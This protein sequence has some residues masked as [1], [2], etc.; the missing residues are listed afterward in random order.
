MAGGM[1]CFV[2]GA[3]FDEMANSNTVLLYTPDAADALLAVSPGCRLISAIT[4]Q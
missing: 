3:G 1:E 2:D 4:V